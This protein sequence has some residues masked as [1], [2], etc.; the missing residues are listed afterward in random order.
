ML[1]ACVGDWLLNHA[2]RTD[3]SQEWSRGRKFIGSSRN[4]FKFEEMIV[5]EIA[6]EMELK[7]SDGPIWRFETVT[8][9]FNYQLLKFLVV[10]RYTAMGATDGVSADRVLTDGA[11]LRG[12]LQ[13]LCLVRHG[14]G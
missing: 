4:T 9:D 11:R 14:V 8:T 3:L 5:R 12:T 10:K 7:R 1:Q 6:T 13:S 2:D